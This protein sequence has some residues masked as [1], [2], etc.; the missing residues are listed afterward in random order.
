MDITTI[1]G[2][3]VVITGLIMGVTLEGANLVMYLNL[4]AAFIVLVGT[5]GVTTIT[6]SAETVLK[7]PVILGKAFSKIKENRSEIVSIFV[8]LLGKARKDGILSLEKELSNIENKFFNKGLQLVIDGIDPKHVEKYL[9]T[10]IMQIEERHKKGIAF[11]EAAGGYAPTLGIM[12]TVMG[13][14]NILANLSS[15]DQ[16]GSMISVA[17]IATLYGVGAAN[18]VLLPIAAK[19]K[20]KS[21][22][23]ILTCEMIMEGILS[24]PLS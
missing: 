21:E 8:E 16:I 24:L 20:A 19:L 17:F 12:G 7:L 2:L 1:L 10:E 9:E 15:P 5:F 23:E 13:L 11:F 18:V 4:P 3:I 22:E 14:V 6:T